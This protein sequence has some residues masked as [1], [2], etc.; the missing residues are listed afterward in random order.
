VAR[1]LGGGDHETA[2]PVICDLRDSRHN[3]YNLVTPNSV[4]RRLMDITAGYG[5]YTRPVRPQ[6]S[7]VFSAPAPVPSSVLPSY[8]L[9]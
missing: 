4:A 5:P 7:P 6:R 1:C 3:T 8:V 2:A 9:P